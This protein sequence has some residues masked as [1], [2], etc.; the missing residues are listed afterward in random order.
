M[1]NSLQKIRGWFTG[2]TLW[3]PMMSLGLLLVFNLVTQPSFFRVV[4][5]NGHLYGTVVDILNQGSKVMLLSMGMTLVIGTGGVDLS[6][7]SVM[8]AKRE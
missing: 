1:N 6:V 8:A 3:W 7:G 4:V 5:Q 2:G